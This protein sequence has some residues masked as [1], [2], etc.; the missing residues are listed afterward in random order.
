MAYVL[1]DKCKPAEPPEEGMTFIPDDIFE[2]RLQGAAIQVLCAYLRFSQGFGRLPLMTELCEIVGRQKGAIIAAQ[3][4]LVRAGYLRQVA[5]S[6][7]SKK[8]AIPDDVR[9]EVWERDNFTCQICGARRFLAI[10]H[11]N[12]ESKGGSLDTANLQT[13]CKSCNSRKGDR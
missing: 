6:E 10:D 7:P 2:W 3:K 5:A 11:I 4:E 8:I 12:P 13:L 1:T 9:W